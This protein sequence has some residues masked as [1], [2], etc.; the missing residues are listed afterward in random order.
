MTEQDGRHSI[1]VVIPARDAESFIGDALDSVAAQTR[2][3]DECL[4]VDDGSSDGTPRHV[5]AWAAEH[6]LPV[7]LVQQDWRGLA[8]ARTT[9]VK[10]ASS[11]LIALLDADDLLL[12]YGLE[13]L[14]HGFALWPDVIAV[15]G[16]AERFRMG[17]EPGADYL[18]GKPV[19][20]LPHEEAHAD[21]G[22]GTVPIRRIADGVFQSLLGGSY[23]AN[24]AA[25]VRR[26]AALEVGLW[27]TAFTTGED[28]D[29]WLRL[30]R[31]GRFAYTPR[32]VA[33]V[34]YHGANLSLRRGDAAR[35][36][37]AARVLRGLLR[38]AIPL[39]LSQRERT[40]VR[41][42]LGHAV[43]QALYAGS[44]E[45][46]PGYARTVRA[47]GRAELAIP[48]RWAR[49]RHLARAVL[50]TLTR[51]RRPPQPSTPPP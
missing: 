48:V 37:D 6:D 50:R 19:W 17:G 42:A 28:R 7:R 49:P 15:F 20:R 8:G 39:E 2:R 3:P 13:I 26:S 38:D 33:R 30:S 16:N 27:N 5:E 10:A 21:V 47:L 41:I 31:L 25:L 12:P 1:A 36:T 51:P 29:F 40:S 23:I 46:L 18:T 35:C 11:D 45:G 14:E 44:R 4:V 9:G 34:R 24:C 32:P 22:D 43:E